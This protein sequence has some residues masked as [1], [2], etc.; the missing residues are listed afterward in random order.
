LRRDG[1][2]RYG[3]RPGLDYRAPTAIDQRPSYR[4]LSCRERTVA[5]PE[6]PDINQSGR[7]R[8]FSVERGRDQPAH[9]PRRRCCRLKEKA[10]MIRSLV[11][12]RYLWS[13]H[14]PIKQSTTPSARSTEIASRNTSAPSGSSRTATMALV[15]TD[16]T[17]T[18]PNASA[19]R[20]FVTCSSS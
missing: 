16:A 1:A 14:T 7:C 18:S 5:E 17:L 8:P 10:E 4:S 20:P 15:T 12:F 13:S 9:A 6:R 19:R 2:H 11:L 3:E